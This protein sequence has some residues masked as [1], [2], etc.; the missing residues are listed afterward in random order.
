MSLEAITFAAV[1]K[2]YKKE[3]EKAGWVMVSEDPTR[4]ERYMHELKHLHAHLFA[5][6]RVTKDHD[7]KVDLQVMMKKTEDLLNVLKSLYT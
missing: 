7:K 1:S 2:W 6:F 4:L 3:F 5:K